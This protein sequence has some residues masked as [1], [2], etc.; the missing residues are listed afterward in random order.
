VHC[1]HVFAGSGTEEFG[2]EILGILPAFRAHI[3]RGISSL[4]S[5]RKC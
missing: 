4:G 3:N 5:P 1:A 2:V